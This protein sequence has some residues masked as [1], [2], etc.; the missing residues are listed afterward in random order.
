MK[1]Q[2]AERF[3]NIVSG[4]D[5]Y[6]NLAEAALLI[7]RGEYPEM[8]PSLYMQRLDRLADQ[9]RERLGPSPSASDVIAG[10]NDYLF[11]EMGFRGDL[12]TFNDPRNSFLNEVLDRRLGIPIT[13]SLLYMEI[14]TRLGLYVEGISFPGHF[15]V[16]VVNAGG[17]IVL[18]PF[19]G[20][21]ALNRTELERRL[22]NIRGRRRWRLDELLLPAS[23]RDIIARMLRNL[24]T[25][26]LEQEDFPRALESVNLIL[27]VFPALPGELRDRAQVHERMEC[28]RAAIADYEQYLFLA[29]GAD[30]AGYVQ[31]RLL[32]LKDS[33]VRLH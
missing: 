32:E 8:E 12:Q 27:E 6:I 14:G 18:D 22:D 13:L 4:P 20:G 5:E 7:A 10:L 24:K 23:R 28:V 16:R 9:C 19:G 26:Y 33:A 17:G 15:L 31:A 11:G 1:Q 3:A 30:D 21:R 2:D 29:P 25:I